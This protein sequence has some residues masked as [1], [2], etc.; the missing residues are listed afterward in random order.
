MKTSKKLTIFE[1]CDGSGKTTAAHEFANMTGAKYVHFH[2]LPRIKHG[3]GRIYVEAMLP[4]LLGY[5]D[6]VFDRSW[7]S[8]MPYGEAFREG[9]DRLTNADRRMLERLALRCGAVM[10]LCDP[11]YDTA[12]SNFL[13]RKGQEYLKTT[14]QLRQVYQ[15]YKSQS[16][17]LPVIVYNYTD[18]NVEYTLTPDVER[19][20]CGL[21]PLSLASSGN[22]DAEV[23][24]VGESFAERKDQDPWYQWPFGSFSNEGC[25][26][27]LTNQLIDAGISEYELLWVNSDQNLEFLYERQ[28]SHI[29]AL[30]EK[31]GAELYKMKILAQEVPHPQYHKRFGS[32]AP[33]KLIENLR[34]VT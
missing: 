5:E 16:R 25:S 2:N 34:E 20:R 22:W 7:F 24:L 32:G 15:A 18:G 29:I 13:K 30:G 21:H 14:T 17:G 26:Q 23:I 31:A 12:E 9:R 3:L 8:E 27:W 33:Y 10:V 19:C 1:G 4:A 11:G 6:V 28:T